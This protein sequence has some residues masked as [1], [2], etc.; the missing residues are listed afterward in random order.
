MMKLSEKI[1]K[2]Y[3]TPYQR[4]AAKFNTSEGYV[5]QIACGA[6]I[7]TRGKGLL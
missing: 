3:K 2:V 5:A 4:V 1:K 7:P 6:R